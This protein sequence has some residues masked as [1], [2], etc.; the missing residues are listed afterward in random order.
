MAGRRFLPAL[1]SLLSGSPEPP[2]TETKTISWSG[3]A[4]TSTMYAGTGNIWG[5]EGRA[6]GWDMDRV[7]TEGY[8]R[9]V[10]VFKAVDTIGKHASRLPLELGRGL[11]EEGEFEETFPDHPLL[12]L[13]NGQANPLETG[14]MFRKR[15]SAQILLSKRGAFVE[16]TRSRAGTLTRL[17]LL[18]PDR[19]LPVPDPKGDYISHFELTTREGVIRELPPE[20]VLWI[21][22]PHPTDPFSGITPLEAA[23]ISVDLDHLSRLYNVQFI[24]N[25]ARPGGVIAVDANTLNRQEMDRLESRFLPG[26]EFAGHLSVIASGPGGM[27][28]VDTAAKP[29]DM[30]YE[31]ASTNAKLEILAAF[32]VPESVTGNASGRTFDNAEQEELGFWLHTELCHLELIASAFEKDAGDGMRLRY[33]TSTVE[34]LELPRRKRR[35]EAREE[36]NA[37]LISIDEYRKLAGFAPYANPHTRALWISPQKAPVPLVPGDAAALGIAG[38]PEQGAAPGSVPGPNDPQ[39]PGPAPVEGAAAQALAE[40]HGNAPAAGPQEEPGPAA[41]AVAEARATMPGDQ[42]GPAAAAVAEARSGQGAI[43]DEGPAAAAVAEARRMESK[44]LPVATEFSVGDDDFDQARAAA[45]AAL[46]ALF[47]RQEGV[48]TARLRSPKSRKGTR[49]WLDD[50]PSDT[51]GGS[52]PMDMAKVVGAEKWQDEVIAT[53]TPVLTRVARATAK[54]AADAFGSSPAGTSAGTGAA[55]LTAVAVAADTMRAFHRALELALDEGQQAGAAL[56]DLIGTVG[57]MLGG[58][59]STNVIASIAESAA[60]ATVNGAADAVAAAVGPGIARTWRTRRDERVRPAH[61]AAEGVTL[62]VKQPFEMEGWPVRFPGD[63]LAPR[64]LTVNCRCRL[65]YRTAPEGESL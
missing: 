29:R 3:G 11:T 59:E 5:T 42:P 23:G 24:K 6:D 32:G 21:R 41:A 15:L 62:P 35:A 27:S 36:W 30:N 44:S 16:K 57:Q 25:D 54:D 13:L 1:R 61:A 9:V 37:G 45:V 56:T 28:Y 64:S 14:P 49:F 48:I 55:V 4:Y 47:A 8:E 7:V 17:D 40:A 33:D 60:T 10:W 52:K 34:V 53:L 43:P 51:R 38:G 20:R 12:R 19:V 65:H 26:S 58:E 63:P 31:H 22:D 50:G 46:T 39:Q 18:P 2:A